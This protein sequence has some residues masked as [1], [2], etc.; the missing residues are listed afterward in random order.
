MSKRTTRHR[1]AEVNGI[2]TEAGPFR[3]GVD[4][5][6]E[7]LRDMRT[8]VLDIKAVR[9]GPSNDALAEAV[10]GISDAIMGLEQFQSVKGQ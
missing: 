10:N 3:G 5:W 4:S 7:T 2:L 9:Q 6:I 8:K 1:I